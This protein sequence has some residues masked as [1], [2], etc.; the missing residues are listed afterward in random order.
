MGAL[1]LHQFFTVTD[2]HRT[3]NSTIVLLLSVSWMVVAVTA[4]SY[5]ENIDCP[6]DELYTEYPD[7]ANCNRWE[8]LLKI[9]RKADLIESLSVSSSVCMGQRVTPSVP[10]T[11]CTMWIK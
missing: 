8:L 7:P 9:K 2:R 1:Q 5:S 10:R 4:F 6:G 11:C 3:M